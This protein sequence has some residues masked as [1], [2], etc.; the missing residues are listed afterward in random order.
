MVEATISELT[1]FFKGSKKKTL[2]YEKIKKL[3]R[4]EIF[5]IY[6]I[7]Q[8]YLAIATFSSIGTIALD[9][10]WRRC[11]ENKKKLFKSIKAVCIYFILTTTVNLQLSSSVMPLLRYSQFHSRHICTFIAAYRYKLSDE[12]NVFFLNA[13]VCPMK[14]FN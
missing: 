2:Y 6:K 11:L 5:S 13:A 4:R 9:F 14:Q 3:L 8:I 10:R 1:I 7:Y 12:L